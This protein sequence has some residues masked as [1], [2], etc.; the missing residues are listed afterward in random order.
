MKSYVT[1]TL[2]VLRMPE[3][4]VVRTSEAQFID[5]DFVLDMLPGWI[6]G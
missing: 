4:D 5:G 2:G 6:E 1:P 3:S